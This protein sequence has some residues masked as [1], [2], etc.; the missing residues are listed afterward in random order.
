[1][2]VEKRE[3]RVESG[4]T[5]IEK[6]KAKSEKREWIVLARVSILVN[7]RVVFN[8]AGRRPLP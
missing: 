4:K 7:T 1:M 6:R 8:I 3:G 2:R 5:R